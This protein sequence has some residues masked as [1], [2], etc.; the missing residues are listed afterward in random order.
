M[1]EN[2][3]L[4]IELDVP[5]RAAATSARSTSRF[6]FKPPNGV[7]L[8]IDA[9]VVKGGGYL[10]LDADTGEYAGALELTHRR[11]PLAQGD[12]PDHHQDAGRVDRASRC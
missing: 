10:F 2:I 9:G 1:V 7:G 12:R 4:R 11:L 6:G 8:S 3:G 5:G